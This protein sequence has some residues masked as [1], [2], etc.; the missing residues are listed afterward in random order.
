VRIQVQLTAIRIGQDC[1][2]L[3]SD[4]RA[5][6]R[7]PDYATLVAFQNTPSVKSEGLSANVSLHRSAASSSRMGSGT[8]SERTW[9]RCVANCAHFACSDS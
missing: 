4:T 3:I 6:G 9:I 8:G 2:F 5:P 7:M 1:S